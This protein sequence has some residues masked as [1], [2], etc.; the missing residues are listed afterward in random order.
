MEDISL[1]IKSLNPRKATGPD[2]VPLKVIKFA[3]NVTDS[4]LCKIISKGCVRYIFAS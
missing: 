4:D 1:T 3:S 2:C